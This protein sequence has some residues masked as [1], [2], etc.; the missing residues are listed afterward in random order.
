MNL[1]SKQ[2][3]LSLYKKYEDDIKNLIDPF[4][5][6]FIE[7]FNGMYYREECKIL[8]MLMKEIKPKC[9]IEAAPH[10]GWTTIH[11]EMAL[12]KLAHKIYSFEIDSEAVKDMDRLLIEH[13][14]RKRA[15]II[16]NF[17]MKRV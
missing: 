10:R 5:D 15:S 4:Y 7:D 14:V 11:I 9:I 2:S 16:N 6:E 17:F 8:Y 1:L 12:S 13:E 3:V